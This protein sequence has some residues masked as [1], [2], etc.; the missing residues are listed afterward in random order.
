[1]ECIYKNFADI[2]DR[3]MYDVDYKKWADYVEVIC[4]KQNIKPKMILDLGCGT[5]NFCI[6]MTKRG[7]EMLGIDISPDMLSRAKQ[8][9]INNG[10]DILYLNQNMVEFELYGTVD[11]IVCLMDSINYLLYKKDIRKML[12][13]VNNYLNP[14]GLF[15]FDINSDYK[16]KE[17]LGKNVYYD[18]GDEITYIWQN[19]YDKKRNICEFDLTFFIKE[20]ASYNRYDE[21]HFERAYSIC[22]VKEMIESSNLKLLACYD[23]LR[24]SPPKKESSR[25]FFVCRK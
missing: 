25:I 2:Y 3:L 19:E 5:G 12:K 24:I 10:M 14:G 20:N 1:V 4:K 16:L 9:A 21:V 22:E 11:V 15:I 8:K 17:I 23:E 13:L 18:I 7:Y 6:E